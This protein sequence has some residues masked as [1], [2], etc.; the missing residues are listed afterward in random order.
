MTSPQTAIDDLFLDRLPKSEL[1]I[2]VEGSLEPELL[3][4]LG[5]RNG[6]RLAHG[7]VEA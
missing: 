2:H 3:F 4:A 7:S 6:I 5:R 1:H